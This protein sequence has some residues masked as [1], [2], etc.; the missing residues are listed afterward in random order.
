MR[1]KSPHLYGILVT[2]AGVL[3]LTPDGLLVRLVAAD[4]ATILFWRGLLF[5]IGI[6]GFYLLRCGS[7]TVGLVRAMG[8]RGLLAALLFTFS[9]CF[10]VLALTHTSAANALVIISTAPLFAA[11]FSWLILKES[12]PLSTWIAIG[13]CI[14]GISLIFIG[15]VGGGS[16]HGDFYAILCAFMIAGQITT[17][18]HARNIDMVPSLGISGILTALFALPFSAP[19]AIT[20]LDF[21]YLCILGLIVLPCAFGL[22]TVGPR[23]ISAPEVSLLM[24]MESILGPFWVWLV[25]AEVPR[26]ETVLGGAIVIAT[27]VIHTGIAYRKNRPVPAAS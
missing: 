7:D 3:L 15:S 6:F 9:T 12:I 17:V 11:L 26:P 24:L 23:Y 10:F 20:G 18:R 8:R 13:I 1:E 27:L 22:I 4:S 14:G 16:R 21:T 5:A 19:L 25:L 2:A